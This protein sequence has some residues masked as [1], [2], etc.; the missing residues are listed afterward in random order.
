[1]KALGVVVG[2]PQITRALDRIEL[3]KATRPIT[4]VVLAVLL[5]G[6]TAEAQF[7]LNKLKKAADK[8][9]DVADEVDRF[10]FS[11]DEEIELGLAVSNRIRAR[12][13][14]A[15][16]PE[17]TR[18]LSLVGMS[19]AAK[20]GRSN[21]PWQW[22]ILDTGAVNA[23]AA[24]GGYV[25]VTRGALAAM[26]SEAELA[27]VLAHEVAHVTRKHTLKGLQKSMGMELAQNQ[28]EYAVGSTF[29]NAVADQAAKAVLAGF[30]QAEELEADQVALDVTSQ[31]GYRALGLTNFLGTLNR[32]N[33]GSTSKAGLFRSHPDTDE[34]IKRANKQIKKEKLG[35]GVWVEERFVEQVPY[36]ASDEGTGSP[37]VAGARG[38]AGSD[39]S[40]ETGEDQD[41]VAES[42]DE[43]DEE[44]GDRFS[45]AQL[46]SNP[47]EMGSEEES[48]EVT[49]A[50][51]GRAVGEETGEVEEGAK[52]TE[53]VVVEITADELAA[54]QR[55]GGL[56]QE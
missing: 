9:L 38:M 14:V 20:S 15:Q 7:N 8:A 56:H 42:S 26:Q 29:F 19:V 46:T 51:A 50:G 48:A 27:S 33:A 11:E 54:F 36:E 37:A 35:D 53:I 31:V 28:A 13:G 4:L 52:V 10:T 18:Y 17:V 3:M 34:R 5:G 40:D 44:G 6:V 47:F 22:I 21:L 16:D 1:M 23:F 24:P 43:A 41:T 12:Y 25:H 49:G 2:S 55:E 30:G 45:L 32:I 39:E